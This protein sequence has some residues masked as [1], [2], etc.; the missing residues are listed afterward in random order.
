MNL[1]EKL[2]SLVSQ[3]VRRRDRGICFTC[4]MKYWNGDLG[5]NDWKRMDAGHFLHGGL[6][7]DLM[8]I[9]CQCTNCNRVLGGNMKVYRMKMISRYGEAAIADL[10]R[11]RQEVFKP[12]D[13]WLLA[14]I[15]KIKLLLEVI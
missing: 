12:S 8:N 11:R 3:Y 2:W 14:E 7:F 13:E 6:D 4:G 10:M 5:E 9:H 1:K 15:E